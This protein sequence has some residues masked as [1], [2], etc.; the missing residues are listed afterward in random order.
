MFTAK[1]VHSLATL[2]GT[3]VSH[4]GCRHIKMTCWSSHQNR[5]NCDRSDFQ[6]GMG[7]VPNGLVQIFQKVMVYLVFP[8]QP[9]QGLTENGPLSSERQFSGWKYFFDAW[10][11]RKITK[12]FKFTRNSN[13]NIHTL[14]PKYEEE[15]LWTHNT[16]L[17]QLG[18]SSRRPQRRPLLPNKNSNL[19]LQFAQRMEK[20]CL[21]SF[22]F[23]FSW[24]GQK[25]E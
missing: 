11:Q 5:K 15:H 23:I 9:Y 21:K 7:I 14:Q 12:M 24:Y 6:C 10:G 18:Y 17:K 8:T 1:Y 3:P 25:L 22:I 13:S 20:C 2:L 16:V 4:L 19:I